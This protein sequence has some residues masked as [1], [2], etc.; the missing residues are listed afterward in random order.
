MDR[1]RRE[2]DQSSLETKAIRLI[3]VEAVVEG[4]RC[5][6]SENA[7]ETTTGRRTGPSWPILTLPRRSECWRKRDVGHIRHY[8]HSRSTSYSESDWGRQAGG[9]AEEGFEGET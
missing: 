9:K 2:R 4:E 7:S 5:R 6:T 3:Q 8:R 1:S